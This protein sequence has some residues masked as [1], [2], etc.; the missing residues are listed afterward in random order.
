MALGIEEVKVGC[1][2]DEENATGV[3][4]ILPPAGSLGAIAVRGGAPG[5]REAAALGPTGSGQECHAVVLCG[6]SVF[7]LAAADGVAEWCVENNRGLELASAIVPVVAAAVVFDITG[8]NNP[9]PGPNAG[10]M[11]CEAATNLDPSSG[12]VGVGRG[13]TVGKAAGRG[14][15]SPGGQGISVVQSGDLVVGAIVAVNAFGDVLNPD[16]TV[17]AGSSAPPDTPRYPAVSIEEVAAWESGEEKANT[18]IGC[19]VTNAQL[20]KAEACRVADLA[21]TGIA[22]AIDPPH[23][24][25][26]GD[27]LFLLS[28]QE[29]AAIPDQIANLGTQAVTQAIR[30]AVQ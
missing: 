6:N 2:T 21:H 16:G 12:R 29:I 18:T 14:Y 22:R 9:R 23:T 3:T 27:A 4:A 11:A 13:C 25:V 17:L 28:T 20:T 24:S 10:R 15:A 30:N 19:L 1:W 26:D 8:P 7:G 5:T